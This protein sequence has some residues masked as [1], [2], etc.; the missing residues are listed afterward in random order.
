MAGNILTPS[1]IWKNFAI[2]SEVTAQV[3]SERN[4]GGVILSDLYIDGRDTIDGKVKIFGVF[5]KSAQISVCPA[6]LLIQDFFTSTD[7]K[8]IL[9]LAK[10][11]YSVLAIDLAGKVEGKENYTK[12]P[13]VIKYANVEN[14]A[15]NL[16]EVKG[17]VHG[18]CWYEWTAVARYCLK[19]LKQQQLISKIGVF[20]LGEAATVAWQV[21]GT[22]SVDCAVFALNAGW[23]GYRQIYKFSGE[24]EKQFSDNMYK[25]IAGVEPQSYAMHVKC[26]TLMLTATNSDFYDCDRAYDTLSYIEGDNYR[27]M[28]Y[29][30]GYTNRVS[31]QAYN[32]AV[33]FLDEFLVR[34]KGQIS[35]ANEIEIKCDIKDGKFCGEVEPDLKDIKELEVY[36]SEQ[37]VKPSERCW[38][39]ITSVKKSDGKY[40]FEY[41]PY[42]KSGI[43]MVFAKAHYKNGFVVGSVVLSKRFEEGEVNAINKPNILYSSRIKNSESVFAPAKSQGDEPDKINVKAQKLVKVAKGPMAI[44]GVTCKSGLLTFKVGCDK[45]KPTERAMLML[46]VYAKE[47]SELVIKLISDYFGDNKTEYQV[48]QK[49]L[50]GDVWHN[51]KLEINRFKTEEGMVLKSYE[52]I[53]AMTITVEGVEYLINNALWV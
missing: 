2:E 44:E 16:Y 40:Y 32:D 49:L 26:P 36:V 39:K 19:Y 24:K 10:K 37:I 3:V 31:G 34:G 30:V 9:E 14:V 42:E 4:V 35:L 20:G 38:E 1:L 48:R 51:V 41:S 15:D 13:Q 27:A 12:Y 7:E 29:S 6:I 33:I 22:D 45:Y 25:F 28:H 52:K 5:A 47:P 17:D 50:G 46:D 11:G 53:N 43:I 8:L 18:T 21:A 23:A